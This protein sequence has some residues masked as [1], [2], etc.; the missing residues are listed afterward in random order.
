MDVSSPQFNTLAATNLGIVSEMK[1]YKRAS[2]ENKRYEKK[3]KRT[4][5]DAGSAM[6]IS[7]AVLN[8]VHFGQLLSL[9][10]VTEPLLCS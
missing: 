7:Q 5:S 2:K 10:A 8:L 3:L 1:K 6:Y 9:A 4:S